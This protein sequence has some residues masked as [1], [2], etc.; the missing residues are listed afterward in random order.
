MESQKVR[1]LTILREN[2]E[3]IHS[4]DLANHVG[5]RAAARI[6]DLRRE[7]YSIRSLGEKKGNAIGVRYILE[8]K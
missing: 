5:L 7:G 3:G 1:I 6:A 8:G 2:P 4:F